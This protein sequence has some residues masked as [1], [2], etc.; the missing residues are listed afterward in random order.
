MS[1][2][3]IELLLEAFYKGETTVEEEKLLMQFYFLKGYLQ[4]W[5]NQLTIKF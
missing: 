4:D 2:K 1:E 5:K 3:K